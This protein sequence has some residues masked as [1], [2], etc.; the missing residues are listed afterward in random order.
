M[1]WHH[2]FPFF[3]SNG[4]GPKRGK[5]GLSCKRIKVNDGQATVEYHLDSLSNGELV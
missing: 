5:I 1:L 3:S 4:S 2:L